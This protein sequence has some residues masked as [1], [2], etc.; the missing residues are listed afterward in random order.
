MP[1][2]YDKEITELAALAGEV[3][4]AHTTA[5]FLV[6][7]PKRERLVM[8]SC[9]SPSQ[10]LIHNA[11]ITIGHGL[12][13]WVA[14]HGRPASA[15]LKGEASNLLFYV[16]EEDVKSFAAAPIFEGDRLAGV[17]VVD[18]KSHDIFTEKK[19][20]TLARFASI[21]GALIVRGKKQVKL[22]AETSDV[23]GIAE[24]AESLSSGMP[25]A[26][27]V[28]FLKTRLDAIIPHDQLA[29]ATR[30]LKTGA[31]ELQGSN[32]D[33]EKEAEEPFS[34]TH[35]RLGWVIHQARPI[36][37]AELNAPVIPG[38][39][40]RWRSF[41]GAP[42]IADGE[43]YGAL[44]LLS[45]KTQGFKRSDV[46]TLALVA[47]VLSSAVTA[48]A[49]K[50][51][52]RIA[53]LTDPVTKTVFYRTLLD[54]HKDMSPSGVVALVDLKGFRHVNKELLPKGGDSVLAQMADRMKKSFGGQAEICRYSADTFIIILK[55]MSM[56]QAQKVILAAMDDIESRPFH[57]AGVDAHITPVAG[58][59]AC[60]EDGKFSE[61]LL[62]KAQ[63]G[64][65]VAKKNPGRRILFHGDMD[66]L[67]ITRPV[68]L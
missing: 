65:R 8:V 51:C 56:G 58:A 35:Y 39:N 36:Y 14:K 21:V 26:E 67:E 46:T 10:K 52:A 5:L 44:G 43:V 12:V 47:S 22:H 23:K 3:M 41:V 31:Y 49:L 32:Q 1:H 40:G 48:P 16:G 59:A 53:A 38:D 60:P 54:R 27:L 30:N 20:R 33:G 68:A 55:G 11:V 63:E 64:L 62:I 61:E 9:V 34:L 50:E 45:H 6:E 7:E 2:S 37:L 15:A 19:T 57:Y 42:I 4:E 25:A 18:S 28:R 17:L 24:L 13:G 29:L 66:L